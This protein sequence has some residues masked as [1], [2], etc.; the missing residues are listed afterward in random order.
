MWVNNN[1]QGKYWSFCG[2]LTK[3]SPNKNPKQ[4]KPFH[5]LDLEFNLFAIMDFFFFRFQLNSFFCLLHTCLAAWPFPS[6]LSFKT[7]FLKFIPC[8]FLFSRRN[9]WTIRA[10]QQ[11]NYVSQCL[12]KWLLYVIVSFLLSSHLMFLWSPKFSFV[13]PSGVGPALTTD[14]TT[15]T[16]ILC[17]SSFDTVIRTTNFW[18]CWWQVSKNGLF[19]KKNFFFP[20]MIICSNKNPF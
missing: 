16:A 6:L 20:V 13:L 18:T 14:P 7:C 19:K 8:Y 2:W 11:F 5:L 10:V 17:Q 15:A 1:R 12:A 3:R 9:Y 4:T